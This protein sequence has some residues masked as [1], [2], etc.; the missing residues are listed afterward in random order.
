MYWKY[1][2]LTRTGEIV[3]GLEKKAKNRI[4]GELSQR[5]MRILSLEPDI[6]AYVKSFFGKKA[7]DSKTLVYFFDDFKN[8]LQAGMSV[9]EILS[10]LA[11][12]SVHTLFK[13]YLNEIRQYLQEG[14]SLSQAFS[15]PGIFPHLAVCALRIGEE[16]GELDSVMSELAAFYKRKSEIRAIVIRSSIYPLVVLGI[17]CAVMMFV[18]LKVIP[19]LQGLLPAEAQGNFSTK[20][21]LALGFLLRKVWVV[22]I[23]IPLGG[24]IFYFIMKRRKMNVGQYVYRLPVLGPLLK[25]S[26]LAIVFLNLSILQR[27][28]IPLVQAFNVIQE[29]VANDFIG[30]K[31]SACR[32][33][34]LQGYSLWQAL[35][36]DS[37][38]PL[39]VSQTIRKGEEIGKLDE[40]LRRLADFYAKSTA[41]QI[42]VFVESIQPVL[43]GVCAVYLVLVALSFFLPIYSNLSVIAGGQ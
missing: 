7:I 39:I 25:N 6:P 30:K 27:S 33:S 40:Y 31:I 14:F 17:L 5:H 38:F 1:T 36:K 18:S 21:V 24:I 15:A 42:D 20:V 37:F 41:Q 35:E 11:E 32:E 4:C 8:M 12:T 19:Q 10:M 22:F 13:K 16:A 2:A 9:Q 29:G 3:S 26:S 34:I 28:G 23:F 43:L